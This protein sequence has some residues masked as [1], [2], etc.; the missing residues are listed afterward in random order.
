MGIP[1]ECCFSNETA[2]TSLFRAWRTLNPFN[3]LYSTACTCVHTRTRVMWIYSAVVARS[4]IAF[5]ENRAVRFILQMVG[6]TTRLARRINRLGECYF[7][8]WQVDPCGRI[9]ALEES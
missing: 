6:T 1:A 3:P 5:L 8:K 2:L 7:E 4:D 9:E